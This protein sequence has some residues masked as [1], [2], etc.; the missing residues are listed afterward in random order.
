MK[1]RDHDSYWKMHNPQVGDLVFIKRG[2]RF[3]DGLEN[4]YDRWVEVTK[5]VDEEGDIT[6]YFN[7]NYWGVAL[8]DISDIKPV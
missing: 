5:T 7:C 2:I 8:D 3:Y 6:V 4:Y 1:Y